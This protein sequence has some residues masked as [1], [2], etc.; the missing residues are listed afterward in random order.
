M[1]GVPADLDLSHY[2]NGTCIQI[3]LGESQIQLHFQPAA[4][5]AIE[6]RWELRD[7]AGAIVDQ[8][9]PNDSR[10][11]SRLHLLLAQPVVD[12]NV[13][14]PTSFT[15][16]FSTGHTLEVFDDSTEYE[17]CQLSPSGVII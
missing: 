5:I 12:C 1:Y 15:L 14:A 16:T 9:V 4:T 11:S 2:L 6:G 10:D 3:A 13:N 17:S 7:A 8:S